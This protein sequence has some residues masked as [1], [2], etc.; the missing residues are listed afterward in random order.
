MKITGYVQT[1]APIHITDATEGNATGIAT[2]PIPDHETGRTSRVPGI[3]GTVLRGMLRKTADDIANEA[4]LRHGVRVPM[5]VFNALRHGSTSGR[6]TKEPMRASAFDVMRGHPLMGLFGGGP[7]SSTGLLVTPWMYPL[8]RET[9]AAGMVPP[10]DRVENPMAGFMLIAEDTMYPRLDA[11]HKEEPIF[12]QVVEDYEAK[13]DE[14]IAADMGRRTGKESGEGTESTLR[15][16]N[17]LVYKF[18]VPNVLLHLDLSVA[19]SAPDHV[20]G[21]L[22]VVLAR[23]LNAN[24]VGGMQRIGMGENAFNL[25]SVAANVRLDGETL[26]EWDGH[27]LTIAEDGE[28]ARLRDAFE[29]WHDDGRAWTTESLWEATGF[30]GIDLGTAAVKKTPRKKA[31]KGA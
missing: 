9:L 17:L 26:F 20:K 29:E 10:D 31:G 16:S 14:M 1:V 3:K 28:A 15:S 22:L 12:G 19:D 18:M 23:A 13:T 5:E 8:C 30:T 6:M 2:M 4:M 21:F 27:E 25:G 24:R 7:R 11:I